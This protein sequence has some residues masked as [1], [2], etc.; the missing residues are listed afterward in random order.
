MAVNLH[1]CLVTFWFNNNYMIALPSADSQIQSY[2][3][4][5]WILKVKGAHEEVDATHKR[6]S[7]VKNSFL[8]LY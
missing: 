6:K 2:D 8:R 5:Y 7:S 3:L 1:C 4:G